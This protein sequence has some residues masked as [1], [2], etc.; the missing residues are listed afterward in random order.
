[1]G[2]SGATRSAGSALRICPASPG[3]RWRANADEMVPSLP[4]RPGYT[5]AVNHS[6]HPGEAESKV[7][8]L[9]RGEATVVG[10]PSGFRFAVSVKIF[11]YEDYAL[12]L[13]EQRKKALATSTQAVAGI[14]R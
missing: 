4:T 1:M 14:P 6:P 11:K 7:E 13:I 8:V 9:D 5:T 10:T 3:R 2:G 12:A